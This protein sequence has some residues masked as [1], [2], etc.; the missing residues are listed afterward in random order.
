MQGG[1]SVGG[2]DGAV[3]GWSD[4]GMTSAHD[5]KAVGCSAPAL[6]IRGV[7]YKLASETWVSDCTQ[8]DETH[9]S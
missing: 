2:R 7:R 5:C 3:K 1:T 4:G 9:G 6:L 8:R